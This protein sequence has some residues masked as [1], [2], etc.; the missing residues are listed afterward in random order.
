MI[1]IWLKYFFLFLNKFFIYVLTITS[2]NE[3][4]RL[5]IKLTYFKKI[6]KSLFLIYLKGILLEIIYYKYKYFKIILSR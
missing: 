4:I 3:N 1:K 2:K 6:R 5:T